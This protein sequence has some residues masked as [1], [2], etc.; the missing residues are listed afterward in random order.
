ME[1]AFV[2][3]QKQQRGLDYVFGPHC[4]E[5]EPDCACYAQGDN[6]HVLGKEFALGLLKEEGEDELEQKDDPRAEGEQVV[7]DVA[8]L[9]RIQAPVCQLVQKEVC[10][11]SNKV[12]HTESVRKAEALLRSSNDELEHEQEA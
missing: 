5:E 7:F 10:V 9:V 12:A 8:H 6:F 4:D 3:S 11:A 2:L 1:K